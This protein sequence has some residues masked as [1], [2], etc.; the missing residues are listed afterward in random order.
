[1]WISSLGQSAAWHSFS[2]PVFVGDT[3]GCRC[4]LAAKPGVGH[5]GLLQARGCAKVQGTGT[6]RQSE[7]GW[8]VVV[9]LQDSGCREVTTWQAQLHGQ[10]RDG[11]QRLSFSPSYITVIILKDQRVNQKMES[12]PLYLGNQ[13]Q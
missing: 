3:Y 11:V 1:M 4:G 12:Y 13:N 2:G 6:A 5:S 8:S 9:V 7:T 10:S